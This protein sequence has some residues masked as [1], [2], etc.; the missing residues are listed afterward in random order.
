MQKRIVLTGGPSAGKTTL[1]GLLEKQYGNL[2]AIA[3]EAATILFRQG[4]PRPVTF[5]DTLNTQRAIYGL[6]CDLE[7]MA[8]KNTS[9]HP[10]FPLPVFCDRG[11]LDGAAYWSGTV[12]EFCFA[13]G[14]T[15]ER[16]IERYV[17]VLHLETAPAHAGYAQ[18][19]VRIESHEEATLLDQKI[20][21]IWS[22][23]PNYIFIPNGQGTFLDKL[24]R[25]MAL[26]RP[27]LPLESLSPRFR[28]AT[29]RDLLK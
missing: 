5:E 20:G 19:Q 4:H 23:H 15:V 8:L 28:Y 10:S 7:A 26:L 13:M 1:L 29:A 3:P 25:A 18:T 9:S 22:K 11:A 21:S 27:F 12:K 24:D 17:A 16:E 14:T 6:Q 2:V